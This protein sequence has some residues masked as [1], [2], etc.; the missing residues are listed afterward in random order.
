MGS[1]FGH[2]VG[3]ITVKRVAAKARNLP[4]RTPSGIRHGRL[5]WDLPPLENLAVVFRESGCWFLGVKTGFFEFTLRSEDRV[6]LANAE[7][8]DP[9]LQESEAITKVPQIWELGFGLQRS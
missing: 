8:I 3:K 7:L 2:A 6:F 1:R 5:T 9:G 4:H